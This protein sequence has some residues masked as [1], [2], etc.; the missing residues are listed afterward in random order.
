[1]EMQLELQKHINNLLKKQQQPTQQ[2][3][4]KPKQLKQKPKQSKKQPFIV[5]KFYN[6]NNE[7]YFIKSSF[8]YE[9]KNYLMVVHHSKHGNILSE[10]S[11]TENKDRFKA[12]ET[13]FEWDSTT[14]FSDVI[15]DKNKKIPMV[16]HTKPVEP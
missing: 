10:F 12:V 6:Y 7:K 3:Q 2:E 14:L 13:D 4:P 16:V 11:V 1:M 15:Y 5:G 9:N 8:E